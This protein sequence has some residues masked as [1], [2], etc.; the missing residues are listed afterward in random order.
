[1]HP[2]VRYARA[3]SVLSAVCTPVAILVLRPRMPQPIWVWVLV[4]TLPF[5]L[6]PFE[7]WSSE[8]RPIPWLRGV[9]A[10]CEAVDRSPHRLLIVVAAIAVACLVGF[11][12]LAVV[13]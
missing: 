3:W 11:A 9:D 8:Y 10:L 6:A 12:S 1:M 13:A 7:Y 2:A 4:F 5:A